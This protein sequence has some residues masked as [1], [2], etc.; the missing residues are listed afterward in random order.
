MCA[1]YIVYGLFWLVMLCCNWRDLL[2]LQFWIGAVIFLGMLE[3][4]VFLAEFESINN[5][6]VSVRGA[7]V[8]AELVSCMKRTLARMLIVIVS[9]GF[10]IVK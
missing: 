1:V 9:L 5:T 3:K 7:A 2:R 6:G 8:F 10:G 4:A